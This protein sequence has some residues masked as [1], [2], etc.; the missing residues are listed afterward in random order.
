MPYNAYIVSCCRSAM[1]KRNGTLSKTHPSDLGAAVVDECVKRSQVP[2]VAVDDV[3]CGCVSQIGAQAGNIGRNIVLSSKVLPESVP[4]TTVDRQCGSSQQALHFAAQA[5]MSGTQ[6]CVIA[7]GVEVMSLVPIAS[8]I[9]VGMKAKMG[10]PFGNKG[11]VANYGRMAPSQFNGAELLAKKHHITRGEMDQFAAESHRRAHHAQQ[12]GYFDQEI[13]PID[14]VN[15]KTGEPVP[16]FRKDEGIRPGTTVEGLSKLKLLAED[17]RITAGTSSQITDGASAVMLVNENALRRFPQLRPR[18]RIVSLALAGTDPKIML[19]GPIPAGRAALEKAGLTIQDMD[20]YEVNEA[21]APVPMSFVK[22][23]G[24]D[25]KKLNPNGGAIALGHPLGA[26]GTRLMTTM[27][28]D[29]ERRS[30][31]Y[32][33]QAICEGGGTANATIIERVNRLPGSRL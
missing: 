12:N 28:H 20:T 27:V 15:P 23:L 5:V 2:P 3:I 13:V 33:I 29:M 10:L 7:C 16:G 19:E 1:G 25:H 14:G 4:G 17:G 31:R 22:A 18:A 11:W 32:G 21:F 9:T 6:D 8:N 26:T 30:L 24:G